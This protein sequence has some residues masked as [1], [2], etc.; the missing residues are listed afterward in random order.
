MTS[1]SAGWPGRAEFLHGL[2]AAILT[3][4]GAALIAGCAGPAGQDGGARP[5]EPGKTP[6]TQSSEQSVALPEPSDGKTRVALLL[7]LS[8]QH[9][10]LGS[11]MQRAAEM[12]LFDAGGDNFTLTPIDTQGT[13]D[14][15][16]RAFDQAMSQDAVLILGPLFSHSAAALRPRIAE[17]G[18][19]VVSF[20]NDASAAGGGIYVMGFLPGQ[21]VDRVVN[22]AASQGIR[23]FAALAPDT[24]F[25]RRIVGHMQ[26]S[27]ADA[28][29]S[30]VRTAFYPPQQSDVS[31]TVKA[32]AD[33]DARHAA[34]QAEIRRLQGSNDA[35]AQARLR[36]IK[37]L[38]TLGDVPYGAV[39]LPEGGTQLQIV[40][41]LL[42]YYDVDPDQVQFLG[43]G[44]WDDPVVPREATLH[45]GWFA[46]TPAESRRRFEQ[47]YAQS[48][49]DRPPRLATLAYDATAMAA[50][51]AKRSDNGLVT[52]EML[53]NPEGFLGVDGLFRFLPGG[54]NER[55]LAV[56]EVQ[57]GGFQPISPAPQRFEPTGP[58][59]PAS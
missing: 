3:I 36:R 34:L 58:A 40:G 9:A 38:D 23:E 55:G 13:P 56:L 51:L 20:S 19:P 32:F 45:G 30:L 7:P 24:E 41:S 57:R 29:A 8:G 35:G 39:L 22:Y 43:T 14:G 33:Y 52:H 5:Y 44:Q 18:I 49:G 37:D 48:Y 1:I 2:R 59:G 11:A 17:S 27:T 10:A 42:A 47:R 16:S 53:T 12:A 50:T 46:S 6:T 21:Q 26:K 31:E 15:A 25:G 54:L 28:G 4:A